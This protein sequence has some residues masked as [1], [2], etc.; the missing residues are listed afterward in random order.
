MSAAYVAIGAGIAVLVTLCWF[1]LKPA[2]PRGGQVHQAGTNE[3]PDADRVP[4]SPS[5]KGD[6]NGPSI[7]WLKWIAVLSL[8]AGGVLL[9]WRLYLAQVEYAMEQIA[10]EKDHPKP[11]RIRGSGGLDVLIDRQ[12]STITFSGR[13][14]L[15]ILERTDK[16]VTFKKGPEGKYSLRFSERIMPDGY[17]KITPGVRIVFHDCSVEEARW[18]RESAEADMMNT[19]GVGRDRLCRG[20]ETDEFYLPNGR[21]QVDTSNDRNLRLKICGGHDGFRPF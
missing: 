19:I 14:P 12:R 7:N 4:P 8:L 18:L 6:G 16:D 5:P 17:I 13:A 9:F 2:P 3:D 1:L 20:I 21:R 15:P 10:E 11:V